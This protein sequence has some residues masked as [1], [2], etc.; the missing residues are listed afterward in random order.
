MILS[1]ASGKGGTGKTTVAVNLALSLSDNTPLQLLDCDVEEPNSHFLLKP[2]IQESRRVT[3]PVPEIDTKKCTFCGLCSE[4]CAYKAL[5]VLEDDVLVFSDLCHGCGGC[6]LICPEEA[7]VET[8]KR[9]GTLE[10]GS[11]DKI[12]FIQGKMDIGQVL[13][14]PIIRETKKRIESQTTAIIDAPPGTSCP[15]VESVK[16]SDFALLVTEPTPFGLND[17]S[18]A[19]DILRKMDIPF[20]VLINRLGQGNEDVQAYC[21]D[22]D[23]PILM[24]IPLDRRI[25]VAY[26]QGIPFIDIL[27]EYRKRFV[28]MFRSIERRLS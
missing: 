1:I 14:P 7:I 18:L 5:A 4:F 24:C 22:Q 19:V 16:D 23:I 2:N 27:P 13:S 20:G 26:S 25:A 8:E 21:K 15:M 10:W 3:I 9:I 6:R 17:L 11:A 28:E 12:Q